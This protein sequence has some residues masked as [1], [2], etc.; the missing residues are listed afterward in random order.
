MPKDDLTS[1][2]RFVLLTLMI[3]T[4]PMPNPTF[5][6]LKT[7]QR[8]DLEKRGLIEIVGQRPM[9]LELTQR[10][11]DRALEELGA[12]QPDRT[13]S[14]GLALYTALEFLGRLIDHTGADPRD[15]F[16][17]RLAGPVLPAQPGSADAA[18]L[19]ERIRAVYRSLVAKP[20]DFVM[21]DEVRDALPEVSRAELDAALVTMNQSAD[22]HLIPESNQKVL[23]PRQ[24]Q[25]AV[26]IGNQHRHLLGIGA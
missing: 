15:L 2:Q 19:D 3:K 7:D 18:A 16:R 12:E 1:V 14:A 10:G 6:S 24:R 21:L 11:Q 25:A 20:G 9:R 22:V 5:G 8:K 17:L 23:T 13:G 4:E 26:S